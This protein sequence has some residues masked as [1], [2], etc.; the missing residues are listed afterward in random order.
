MADED[1]NPDDD[2]PIECSS[3]PC[4]LHEVWDETAT[5]AKE[6]EAPPRPNDKKSKRRR[7]PVS[8]KR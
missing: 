4:L 3:P 2:E 5:T 8:G 1:R 7:A 6:R